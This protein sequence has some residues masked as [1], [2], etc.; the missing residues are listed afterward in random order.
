MYL[1]AYK[2]KISKITKFTKITQNSK[3]SHIFNA[4]PM[5]QYGLKIPFLTAS[6]CS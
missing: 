6:L 5:K 2:D 1:Q 3:N 4:Q